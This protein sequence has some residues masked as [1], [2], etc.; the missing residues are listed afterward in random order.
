[1]NNTNNNGNF[2][3]IKIYYNV[4]TNKSLILSDNKGRAA[5]YMWTNILSGKRYVG[6]SVDLLNRLKLYF[7]VVSLNRNKSMYINNAL[8]N[9]GYSAFTLSILEYIDISNLSLEQTRKLILEREQYYLDT[10]M[11]EYNILAVA[12]S[13]LGY[14]HTPETITFLSEAN[15]GKNHPMFEITGKDHPRFGI[16]LSDETKAKMSEVQ[17]SIDRTGEKNPRGMLGRS[18]SS[19]TLIKMS[20]AKG[21]G[22]IFVYSSDKKFLLYT[23]NSARKAAS[24][25]N[26]N[27]QTIMRYVRNGEIFKE[28]WILSTTYINT[29]KN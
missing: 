6:S 4:E 11:P 27:H 3:P 5:I 9:H 13:F 25:F 23:F 28:Q 26:T 12:G 14:K 16:F 20:I 8:L 15:K 21:G 18:H 29:T 17:K 1:M 10:L 22:S 24:H 19:D 7:S 2:L